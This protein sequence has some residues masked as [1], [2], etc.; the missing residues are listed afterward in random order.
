MIEK[1]CARWNW[2]APARWVSAHRIAVEQESLFDIRNAAEGLML[3]AAE[4]NRALLRAL[5]TA[6][7]LA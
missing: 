7:Q 5:L 2:D 1:L 3:S 6:R 4:I